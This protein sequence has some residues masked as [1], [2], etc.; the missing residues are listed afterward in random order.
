MSSHSKSTGTIK[1]FHFTLPC[2]LPEIIKTG[3][4]VPYLPWV[5]TELGVETWR[6]FR[7]RLS[8]KTAAR[9]RLKTITA[10][11]CGHDR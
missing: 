4:L 2:R 5:R 10:R 1:L 7:S 8:R 9:R 11:R 3:A 6:H